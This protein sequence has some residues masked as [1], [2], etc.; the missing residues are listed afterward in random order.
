MAISHIFLPLK[1][2]AS[3]VLPPQH[4][5]LYILATGSASWPPWRVSFYIVHLGADVDFRMPAD[6]SIDLPDGAGEHAV[7]ADVVPDVLEKLPCGVCTQSLGRSTGNPTV[8][9]GFDSWDRSCQ[10]RRRLLL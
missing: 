6:L 1:P 3:T 10:I 7:I 4:S 5:Y 9:R 2:C 8:V